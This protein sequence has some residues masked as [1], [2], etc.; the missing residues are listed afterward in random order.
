[1][2]LTLTR[3]RFTQDCTMGEISLNGNLICKSLEDVDR[4][5][6]SSMPLSELQQRKVYGRTAIPVGRYR[7]EKLWWGAHNAFYPHLL[8]VPGY[9][10]V[11]MHGG[12]TDADTEGCLLYGT[13]FP[14]DN[15]L[16]GQPEARKLLVE[17]LLAAIDKGDEAWI[18]ITREPA[19]WIDF[20]HKQTP[21]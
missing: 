20:L 21:A 12:I 11:L 2:E 17:P 14:K 8:N 6:D 1:M 7:I 19:A 5:L 4:G 15:Y 18:T 10:G 9:A 16:V 3:S 13:A